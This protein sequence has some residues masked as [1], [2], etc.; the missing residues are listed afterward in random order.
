METKIEFHQT[1]F[2]TP[3]DGETCLCFNKF[4]DFLVLEWSEEECAFYDNEADF[5]HS[6]FNI[7]LWAELPKK[8]CKEFCENLITNKII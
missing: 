3:E 8:Q 2:E 7:P 6:V 1:L 4:W 5:Y